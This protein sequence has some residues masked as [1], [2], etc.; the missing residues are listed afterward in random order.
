MYL[1]GHFIDGEKR[2]AD[3][4][5]GTP[6]FDPARGCQIGWAAAAN[7]VEVDAAVRTSVTALPDWSSTPPIARARV[8]FDYRALLR[9]HVDELAALVTRENGKTLDDARG[10]I[11]RGIE[12]V[13]FA[14]GIPQL[15]KGEHSNQV[16]RGVDTWSVL[17]PVGVCVGI[18]PFN[19][20]AMVPLWMIPIAVAC[21]NTFVL[22]PSEKNP[23]CPLRLASLFLEA[24]GPPG[25]FNVINGGRDTADLLIRHP[26]VSAVSFVGSTAVAESIYK[27]ASAAGKRVQALGGAKNH[28]VVMPDADLDMAAEALIGAAY[29]SA[30]QRCMAVS[31]VVAVGAAAQ[32]LVDR[33]EPRIRAI[34]VGAGD[35]PH[36]QMG[37]LISSAA[38]SKTERLIGLGVEQ[39]ASLR[40]DGRMTRVRGC[41]DGYFV[42]ATLFDHVTTDMDIYRDE[43]FGP[44]LC[45]VRVMSLAEAIQIVRTNPYGNGAA[46]FTQDG[47]AARSFCREVN[48][49]MVGINV[50]IPVPVAHH[51]FG[52]WKR[53]LFGDH[54]V[55]G[56]EGI[57]FYT[58]SKTLTA[59]WPTRL[60]SEF[61]FKSGAL[62]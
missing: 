44:V 46:L 36:T 58:R 16:A 48:I 5:E 50:P 32:G 8:M 57:S 18:T 38:R 27:T 14:C 17:E 24:G 31:V 56:A 6:I 59:R 61:N 13:E 40:V 12:V 28:M 10:S 49:G 54:R 22:K 3:C 55:H 11:T 19:F 1:S 51:S 20:P 52:G 33:L 60:V 41:E 35:E 29:G 2:N 47:A 7:S 45:V 34:T 42:G 26:D 9:A 62:A 23:S 53:S 30:G 43:I 37:P 39:G 21:G 15:L 25:V 4:P